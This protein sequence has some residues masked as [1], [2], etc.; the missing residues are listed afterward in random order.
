[1]LDKTRLLVFGGNVSYKTHCERNLLQQGVLRDN[2]L[3]S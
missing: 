2:T 1:M 3:Y